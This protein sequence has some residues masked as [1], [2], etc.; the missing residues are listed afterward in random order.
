MHRRHLTYT[1]AIEF[2]IPQMS[3]FLRQNGFELLFK[4]PYR[5]FEKKR[6]SAAGKWIAKSIE[7]SSDKIIGFARFSRPDADTSP[8]YGAVYIDDVRNG[9]FD[10][11]DET[12]NQRDGRFPTSYRGLDYS[13]K[14]I[15]VKTGRVQIWFGQKAKI[16][17]LPEYK[18]GYYKIR[19]K[20]ARSNEYYDYD[21][22]KLGFENDVSDVFGIDFS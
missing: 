5:R 14:M 18:D 21:S 3:R 2:K 16:P 9:Q 11:S 19:I 15:N 12:G 1:D 4:G 22:Y 6:N 10:Q 20:D 17:Y 8:H 13:K 7:D